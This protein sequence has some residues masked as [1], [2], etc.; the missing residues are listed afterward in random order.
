MRVS[1][2][3]VRSTGARSLEPQ[4]YVERARLA[5][6]LSDSAGRLEWLR[7]ALRLFTETRAMGHSERLAKELA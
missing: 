2:C 1:A 6:I 5:G 3:G 4:I 7:E